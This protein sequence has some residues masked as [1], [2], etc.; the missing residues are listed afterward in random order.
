MTSAS[1]LN[2]AIV[3]ADEIVRSGVAAMLR[4][5]DT[6]RDVSEC[7]HAADLLELSFDKVDVLM[8]RCSAD[9]SGQE[10]AEEA[11]R[12]AVMVVVLLD[13]ADGRGLGRAASIPAHGFLR[14]QGLTAA[15]L[16]D[17]LVRL[18]EGHVVLPTRL[19]QELL[20]CGAYLTGEGSQP[21][22]PTALTPR[23]REVLSLL[24]RGLLNK[25]IA[26]DLRISEHG[27]KRLVGSVLT[28]LSCSSRTLAVA[29]ALREG[30]LDMAAVPAGAAY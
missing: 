27:V 1:G 24:A 18:G 19:A 6:V 9:E 7:R 23:E 17:L 4:S 28:K 25:Q 15:A 5:L 16:G 10:L 3:T 22:R 30:L 13:D 12:H 29:I 20:G 21:T 2:V 14:Q 8:L 11:R 26:R